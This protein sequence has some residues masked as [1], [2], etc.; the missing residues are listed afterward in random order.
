MKSLSLAAA[1]L[2]LAPAAHAATTGFELVFEGSVNLPQVSVTNTGDVGSISAFTI[3]IGDTA[4]NFDATDSE[5]A[6]AGITATRGAGIDSNNLGGLR[7]DTIS[8]T[9]TGFTPGRSFE[10][11]T[12]IDRD[13]ANTAED[14][15]TR[16]LPNGSISVSFTDGLTG[17]LFADLSDGANTT[18]NRFAFAA[19]VSDV[20][21]VPLP[22]GLSLLAL[23]LGALAVARRRRKA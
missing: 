4:F 5:V 16:V 13:N 10:F 15:R 18:G 6:S 9:F 21:P 19:S 20:A 8:Y 17:S 14:F 11:R 1:V 2:A 23:G 12:D 3:T 7:S 22:A